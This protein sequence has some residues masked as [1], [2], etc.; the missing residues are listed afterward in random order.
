M[1]YPTSPFSSNLKFNNASVDLSKKDIS[2]ELSIAGCTASALVK[3]FGSPLFVIDEADFFLRANAWKSALKE[4]FSDGKLYYAAKS[5][6]SIEVAKWLKALDLN[7]D[8]C[9]G[10]ELAVALAADFPTDRIEFHGNNKSVAELEMAVSAGVGT[11]VIDSF[12]EIERIAQIAKSAGKIQNVYIRLTPGIQAHTHEFIS[13]AHED[14]K[15]G[16]SIAS[17][18]AIA[19]VEK[20]LTHKSL[21]L[22]GVHCHIGSQI[23]EVAGF[24]M[25]AQ[26]LVATLAEIK[27]KFGTELPELNIGGGY[28]IAYTTQESAISPQDVLPALAK[29]IKEECARFKLALP[30]ISIEP[31]R[32]IVGPTT[33]TIYEVGTTKSVTLEDGTNRNYISVDGG[34]SDNIRPAL[35]GAKFSAFL[36]NRASTS[37]KI[38]SRIVGKHCETGD[39]LILNIDLAADIAPGDLLAFPATGAYGRSMASNYN[40]IPR[41]AVVAVKDGAARTILRRENQADLLALEVTQAPRRLS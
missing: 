29:V 8:V 30:I 16:F 19:A 24:T 2:G 27:E 21:N 18:A 39:I 33:T 9:T 1:K 41:P 23:F 32:A 17:G 25:A 6:I 7:L 31:G 35:Y 12:I 26:R 14:V 20:T 22:I 15:F 36:A 13:T 4:S 28:G 11:I 3:E 38:S 37:E 10:G 34:M 40:H 5:F